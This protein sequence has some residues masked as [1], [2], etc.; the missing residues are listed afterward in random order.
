MAHAVQQVHEILG[1][2]VPGRLRG[3]GAAPVPPIEASKTIAQTRFLRGHTLP[4]LDGF[5]YALTSWAMLS[6]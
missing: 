6:R 1:G 2:Y 5:A 3:E 4:V